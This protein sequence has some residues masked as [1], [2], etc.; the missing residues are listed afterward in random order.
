MGNEPYLRD[1]EGAGKCG[2]HRHHPKKGVW[3]I[4]Q[5][6]HHGQAVRKQQAGSETERMWAAKYCGRGLTPSRED[7]PPRRGEH[8]Q[9]RLHH[10]NADLPLGTV[11][12]LQDVLDVLCGQGEHSRERAS[13]RAR[14]LCP[15]SEPSPPYLRGTGIVESRPGSHRS[16]AGL[17][18][19]GRSGA[20]AGRAAGAELV[21]A[22]N[23]G[24][25]HWG[26]KAP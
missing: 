3:S 11:Q 13:A 23:R 15:I 20:A 26:D 22:R 1:T 19:R 10:I 4:F 7:A 6:L 18:D 5:G 16:A 2:S 17:T 8:S 9:L 12:A 24:F 21:P 25:P 14:R